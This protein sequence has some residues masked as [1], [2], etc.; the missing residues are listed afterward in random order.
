VKPPDFV[1]G[2]SFSPL[3]GS[4]PPRW[5][6]RLLI[7]WLHPTSGQAFRGVRT[8]EATTYVEYENSDRELYDLGADRYQ[9]ENAY[10]DADPATIA[11][12]ED[13][14]RALRGCAREA[15]RRAEGF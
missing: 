12:L 8:S 1:D 2:L 11:R 6:E 15:C 3:L 9:L 5:R 7:E 13:Q 14:L 4:S 10:R